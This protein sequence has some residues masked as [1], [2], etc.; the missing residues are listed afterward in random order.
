M[1]C[2]FRNLKGRLRG[3]RRVQKVDTPAAREGIATALRDRIDDTAAE[4]PELGRNAGRQ[5]LRLIN[6]ILDEEVLRIGKQV[7]IDVHSIDHE[8]IVKSEGAVDNELA[9]VRRILIHPRRKLGN[10]L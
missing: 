4:P 9:G 7:V 2:P 5:D 3:P 8:D 6:R 10:A 1:L